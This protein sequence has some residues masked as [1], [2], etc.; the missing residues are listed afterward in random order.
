MKELDNVIVTND[1]T[2]TSLRKLF[3]RDDLPVVVCVVVR[4]ASDLL[5]WDRMSFLQNLKGHGWRCDH[6]QGC[7]AG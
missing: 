1:L 6:R 7:L 3:R 4:I 2:P 5:A